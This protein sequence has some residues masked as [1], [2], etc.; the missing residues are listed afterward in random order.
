MILELRP[1]PERT[2]IV[3]A[4]VDVAHRSMVFWT[5]REGY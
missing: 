2:Q 3:G 1:Y 4:L 5:R